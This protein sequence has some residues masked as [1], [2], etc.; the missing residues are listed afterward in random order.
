MCVCVSLY[1]CTLQGLYKK[2]L[3]ASKRLSQVAVLLFSDVE[4]E[5]RTEPFGNVIHAEDGHN[6][7]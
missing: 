2:Y 6:S 7:C 1:I 3:S 5:A 4:L